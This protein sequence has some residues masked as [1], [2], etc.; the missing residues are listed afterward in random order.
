MPLVIRDVFGTKK[1]VDPCGGTASLKVDGYVPYPMDDSLIAV[2]YI[3]VNQ[4]GTEVVIWPWGV[5]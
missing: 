2:S 4:T 3:V 5:K 1:E